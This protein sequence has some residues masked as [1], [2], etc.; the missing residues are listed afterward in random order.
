MNNN[1]VANQWAEA[2]PFWFAVRIDTIATVIMT[3]IAL[4]C[5]IFR[6][7]ANPVTLALLL[8][9]SL[10]VQSNTISCIRTAMTLEARMVNA[11][12][13]LAVLKVP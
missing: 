1:I 7:S 5:V 3:V 11:E 13:V 4:F 10:T 6:N 8:T 2:V 12:R 9:Y